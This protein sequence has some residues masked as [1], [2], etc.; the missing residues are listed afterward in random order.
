MDKTIIFVTSDIHSDTDA[1]KAVI[2]AATEENASKLLIG[3]TRI[4]VWHSPRNTHISHTQTTD[5]SL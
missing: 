5:I 4:Q 2:E 1:L 3:T